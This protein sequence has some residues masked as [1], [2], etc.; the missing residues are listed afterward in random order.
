MSNNAR[1]LLPTAMMATARAQATQKTADASE[2][3]K[4]DTL[5]YADDS[6]LFVCKTVFPF[7]LF[8]DVITIDRNKITVSKRYFLSTRTTQ[9][10]MIKDVMTIVVQEAFLFATL[11][12]VDRMLPHQKITVGPL[13]KDDARMVRK[14]VEGLLICDKEKIDLSQIPSEDLIP[15]LEQIGKTKTT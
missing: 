8:P 9:S 13:T 5:A 7:D 14:I 15:R 12:V 4:L 10:M 2:G 3:E 11:E 1:I 6:A